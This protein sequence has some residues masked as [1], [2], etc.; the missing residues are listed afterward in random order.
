[1]MSVK[2]QDSEEIPLENERPG[3]RLTGKEYVKTRIQRL[4]REIAEFK[5]IKQEEVESG[6][7]DGRRR[8]WNQEISK[9]QEQIQEL[10]AK[11]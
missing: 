3:D 5:R 2:F 10:E 1:M 7:S 8:Y 6:I 4:Q 11:L 9:N